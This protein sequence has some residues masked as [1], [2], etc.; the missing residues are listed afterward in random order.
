MME[1]RRAPNGTDSERLLRWAEK[2]VLVIALFALAF[3]SSE[4]DS[5]SF[6]LC[7]EGGWETGG[8]G[9]VCRPLVRVSSSAG[10]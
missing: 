1:A 3:S 5:L 2:G 10:A 8:V 9:Y 7:R 6:K 4:L